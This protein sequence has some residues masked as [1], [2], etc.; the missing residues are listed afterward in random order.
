MES[1]FVVFR[2]SHFLLHHW[3]QI[4]KKIRVKWFNPRS[5]TMILNFVT[6]SNFLGI[7][8]KISLKMM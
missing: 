2:K 8:Y 7:F 4:R 3:N 5:P 1:D 6:T